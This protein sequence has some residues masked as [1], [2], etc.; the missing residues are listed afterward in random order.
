MIVVAMIVLVLLTVIG[1][2]ATSTSTTEVQISTNAVLHNIAFYLIT[3]MQH[4]T[5]PKMQR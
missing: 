4:R 3:L 2:S 5:Q 1:I